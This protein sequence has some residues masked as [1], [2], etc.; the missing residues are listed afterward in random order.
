MMILEMIS[1]YSCPFCYLAEVRL[2]K[3]LRELNAKIDVKHT[4]YQLD[5]HAPNINRLNAYE[6]FAQ[7]YEVDIELAKQQM[8]PLEAKAKTMGLIIDY[9]KVQSTNTFLAH[10]FAKAYEK[11]I[12]KKDIHLK[13]YQAYFEKGYNLSDKNDLLKVG[14]DCDLSEEEA[15]ELINDSST[16]VECLNDLKMISQKQIQ[17]IPQLFHKGERLI[18]GLV[19]ENIYK[20]KITSAYLKLM[21]NQ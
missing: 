5:E 1:D 10:R 12:G 6:V 17:G 8:S 15:L 2:N 21:E 19:E 13:L 9:S 3:V 7:K 16:L 18:K 20:E 11:K 14:M 4:T